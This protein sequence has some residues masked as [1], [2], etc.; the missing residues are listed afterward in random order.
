MKPI[1]TLGLRLA[2]RTRELFLRLKLG[3]S[4]LFIPILNSLNRW[5]FWMIRLWDS[6][7]I[8]HTWANILQ[9]PPETLLHNWYKTWRLATPGAR[10]VRVFPIYFRFVFR[11]RFSF[12]FAWFLFSGCVVSF[13]VCM[14]SFLFAF[15]FGL[16]GFFFTS[17]FSFLFAWFPLLFAWFAAC[18]L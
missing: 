12:L 10:A 4:L 5:S 17:V 7:E 11:F 14:V 1:L 18:P 13:F 3:R 15:F 9:F 6:K 16:R 2:H 8:L